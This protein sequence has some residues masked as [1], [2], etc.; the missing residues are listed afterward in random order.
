LHCLGEFLRSNAQSNAADDGWSSFF[1]FA[2]IPEIT[3]A[4]LKKTGLTNLIGSWSLLDVKGSA[5]VM[6][7]FALYS[8]ARAQRKRRLV[9]SLSR[10]L[11]SLLAADRGIKVIVFSRCNE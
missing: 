6:S 8:D 4:H 7:Q 2:L 5:L 9:T 10:L 1:W 11:S 3:S